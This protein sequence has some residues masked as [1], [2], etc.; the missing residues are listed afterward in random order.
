MDDVDNDESDEPDEPD[1]PNESDDESND[2]P[3]DEVVEDAEDGAVGGAVCDAENES[4]RDEDNDNDDDDSNES[5]AV[6][7]AGEP[8][9]DT[10]GER[11]RRMYLSPPSALFYAD[12]AG[13]GNHEPSFDDPDQSS[14]LRPPGYFSPYGKYKLQFISLFS[15][16][17]VWRVLRQSRPKL[18][19]LYEDSFQMCVFQYLI[20]KNQSISNSSFLYCLSSRVNFNHSRLVVETSQNK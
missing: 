3:E 18:R 19:I 10:V 17:Y 2:E 5:D 1:E 8:A 4:N 15:C 9:I 16:S 6:E 13:A 7:S 11:L 20:N 14:V 12:N